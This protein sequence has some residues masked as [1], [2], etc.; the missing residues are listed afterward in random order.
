[1][2]PKWLLG[3]CLWSKTFYLHKVALT[4]PTK[5]EDLDIIYDQIASRIWSLMITFE[6]SKHSL[7]S[8][9]VPLG[10]VL[11]VGARFDS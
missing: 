11:N 9:Y 2:F 1:M 3:Y 8:W 7:T 10:R 5:D 6:A 4:I